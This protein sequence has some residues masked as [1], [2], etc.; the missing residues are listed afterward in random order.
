MLF[1]VFISPIPFFYVAEYYGHLG[2]LIPVF[3]VDA[4]LLL[5]VWW[6]LRLREFWKI[7]VITLATQGLG[8]AG[9]LLGLWV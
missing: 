1:A 2:Y 6:G 3:L 4:L 9:F 7:R 8:L 5:C